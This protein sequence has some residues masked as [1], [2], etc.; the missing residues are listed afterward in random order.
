ML[1]TYNICFF[2]KSGVLPLFY[3]AILVS[4]YMSYLSFSFLQ[5]QL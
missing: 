3:T 5:L 4:S 2:S 1:M